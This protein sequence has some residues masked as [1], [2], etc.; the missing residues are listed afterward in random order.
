M[1]ER[2]VIYDFVAAEKKIAAEK[3]GL[4]VK[5]LEEAQHAGELIAHYW[6]TKPVYRAVDLDAWI[7]SLPT[8]KPNL[9]SAS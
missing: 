5:T 8:E 6:G 1:S 3:V 4:S 2:T 9:R 7:E